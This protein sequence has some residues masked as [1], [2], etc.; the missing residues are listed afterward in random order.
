MPRDLAVII[1]TLNEAGNIVPLVE[2]VEQAL[3]GRDWEIVFVDDDSDDGTREIIEELAAARPEIRLLRRIGRRGL[4][5]ASIEGMLATTAR[6]IAV[7]DADLQH[8]ERLLPRMLEALEA[9]ALDIVVA[10]RYMSGGSAGD[11]AAGRKHISRLGTL[12]GRLLLRSELT[13]PMSGFFMIRREAFAE[14]APALSGRGF[15][16]LLDIMASAPRPLKSGEVPFTFRE[17]L[18]GASKLD[19]LVS[20]EFA[21]LLADKLA[22]RTIP[23]RFFT[24]LSAAA[25]GPGVHL[26]ALYLVYRVWETGFGLAQA[27][28][29]VVAMSVSHYLDTLFTYRSHRLRGR[30]RLKEMAFFCLFGVP[31]AVASVLLA[32]YLFQLQ[33]PWLVA[34]LMGA[35]V[36]AAW[37]YGVNSTLSWA[38]RVPP[39]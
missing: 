32:V 2:G 6:Y 39:G 19:A 4:A 12:G 15:K 17:R 18:S 37:T 20:L 22:G 25:V 24:F 34:G 7:M 31:G 23:V 21:M 30:L 3:E 36:S 33:V 10:S 1:P 9:D 8:D 27:T 14:L 26:L 35:L 5:S 29:T 11:L 38:R 16:I 28:A 13:D